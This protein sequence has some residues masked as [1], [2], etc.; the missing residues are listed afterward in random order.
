MHAH[1]EYPRNFQDFQAP[2][3]KLIPAQVD[4][5]EESAC[6]CETVVLLLPL[7]WP[8]DRERLLSVRA[9]VCGQGLGLWHSAD[10]ATP[11]RMRYK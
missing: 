7:L 8:D 2:F 4:P 11:P 6:T 9:S 3:L 1:V 10:M 5:V